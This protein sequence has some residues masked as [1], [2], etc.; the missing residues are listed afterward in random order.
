MDIALSEARPIAEVRGQHEDRIEAEDDRHSEDGTENGLE[1]DLS[2]KQRNR[3]AEPGEPSGSS[4]QQYSNCTAEQTAGENDSAASSPPNGLTGS[5]AGH[6]RPEENRPEVERRLEDTRSRKRGPDGCPKHHDGDDRVLAAEAEREPARGGPSRSVDA[7]EISDSRAKRCRMDSSLVDGTLQPNATDEARALAKAAD[8]IS[9]SNN[10]VVLTGAGI[11]TSLGIP[12]FR[13]KGTGLY[14]TLEDSRVKHP[15]HIFGL[16]TFEADPSIFYSAAKNIIPPIMKLRGQ[17]T[18]THAFINLLQGKGK[19]QTNYTQN[20]DNVETSAGIPSDKLIQ[21]HGSLKTATCLICKKIWSMEMFIDPICQGERPSCPGCKGTSERPRRHAA[22]LVKPDMIFFG[23][24]LPTSFEKRWKDDK[25]S[26]DLVLAIGTSL[27]VY[28]VSGLREIFDRVPWV[29]ISKTR[30]DDIPFDIQLIGNCDNVVANLCRQLEWSHEE[31]P[32]GRVVQQ[33]PG[34]GDSPQTRRSSEAEVG[35]SDGRLFVEGPRKCPEEDSLV[36]QPPRA[37]AAPLL[38]LSST[39]V[40][41]NPELH[42]LVEVLRTKKNIVVIA[43]AGISVSA[44]IP[45]FRSPEGLFATSGKELFHI[46]VYNQNDSTSAFHNMVCRLEKHTRQADPTPFH[47][48]LASL[49]AE[50]RLM[51]LYTQNIDCIDTSLKPLATEI[52]LN[53]KEPWPVTI[54]LHGGLGRMVCNMCGYIMPFDGNQFTSH[55]APLCPKCKTR[56]DQRAKSNKRRWGVGRMRPRIT[57][58]GED[59]QDDEVIAK[60]NEADVR[61]RPDALLVVGTSLRVPGASRLAKRVCKAT[62]DTGGFTAWINVE[63]RLPEGF[64]D[65]FD[66]VVK[67]KCDDVASHAQLPPWDQATSKP[68]T[69]GGRTRRKKASVG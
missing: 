28:P 11:S 2:S 21:C 4:E 48:L 43:G 67:G 20:I 31:I 62:R 49:A 40:E 27:R 54:Q 41:T 36:D 53:T 38:D 39:N 60:V 56:D 68:T 42:R 34:Q 14:S 66:L 63:D 12:D 59:G 52:P 17:Y 32:K 13:S 55:E 47:Q 26:V 24:S 3:P 8:Y 61:S 5:T 65:L 33:A 51:R 1:E 69:R 7:D 6:M 64:D 50:G 19:L 58:Y 30:I 10:I 22:G 35:G 44:G 46:N 18:A 37:K 23:D 45:D 25:N 57:L 9:K 15:E 29:N 16:E